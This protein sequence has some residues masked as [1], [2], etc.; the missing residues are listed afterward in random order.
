M[1][2]STQSYPDIFDYLEVVKSFSI[3]FVIGF[4]EMMHFDFEVEGKG[5][6][7]LFVALED[8]FVAWEGQIESLAYSVYFAECFVDANP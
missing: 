3:D 4:L 7:I 1:F 2:D 8:N 5:S 6:W